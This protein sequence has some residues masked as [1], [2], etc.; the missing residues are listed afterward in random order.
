M[1]QSITDGT[2]Q[3]RSPKAVLA[4]AM[5]TTLGSIASIV[6]AWAV[7]GAPLDRAGLAG[8][9][10]GLTLGAI[11]YAGAYI[12]STGTVAIRPGRTG[13]VPPIAEDLEDASGLATAN[14]ALV[15]DVSPPSSARSRRRKAA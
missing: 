3:G 15:G 13:R 1:M 6:I 4:G 14:D 8:A 12:A 5:T 9:L 7:A 2:T 11:A 10:T